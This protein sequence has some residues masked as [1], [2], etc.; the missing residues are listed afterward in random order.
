METIGW[1]IV[2]NEV[3]FE[4]DNSPYFKSAGG[5]PLIFECFENIV[6]L[7]RVKGIASIIDPNYKNSKSE[8]SNSVRSESGL[9]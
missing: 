8:Q 2:F 4:D 5:Q 7:K 6:N 9:S 3:K 1:D